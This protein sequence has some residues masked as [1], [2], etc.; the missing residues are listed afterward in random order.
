[1]IEKFRQILKGPAGKAIALVIV[2]GGLVFM[3]QGARNLF[4]EDSY[5]RKARDRMFV[6]AETAKAFEYT[7]KVG[8]TVPV[9]SPFSKKNTGFPAQL[10]FWTKDGKRKDDP[11]PVL[12]N[13]YLGKKGPTFCPDCGRLVVLYNPYPMEGATPPPTLAEMKTRGGMAAAAAAIR[14]TDD[15]K[16]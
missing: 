13:Q 2:L 10:C 9:Y 7:I 6:C 15:G 16:E 12:L 5:A 11:T 14:E 3:F 1:M 4:G 8:D